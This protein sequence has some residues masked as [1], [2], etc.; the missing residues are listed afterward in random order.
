MFRSI[1]AFLI[2]TAGITA[3]GADLMSA[4]FTAAHTAAVVI[5]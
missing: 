1:I 4:A 5:A 2:V 3:L